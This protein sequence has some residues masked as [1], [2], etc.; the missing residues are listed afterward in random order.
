M[1]CSQQKFSSS[2]KNRND[3]SITTGQ[4]NMKQTTNVISVKYL[5]QKL[6]GQSGKYY[7]F[8]LNRVILSKDIL[9][10]TIMIRRQNK[11]E[12]LPSKKDYVTSS[13]GCN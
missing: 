6:I 8:L 2:T 4:L 11:Q 5:N 3:G 13:N 1:G 10:S 9:N 7:N 12:N